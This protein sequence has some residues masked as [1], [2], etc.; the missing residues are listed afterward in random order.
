M[1][2]SI[3]NRIIILSIVVVGLLFI[4]IGLFYSSFALLDPMKSISF[5]SENL[6]YDEKDSG[7]WKIENSAEWIENQSP[8]NYTGILKM[9]YTR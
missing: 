9:S 6:N 4:M 2:K 1:S 5:T 3:S 7:S 8:E